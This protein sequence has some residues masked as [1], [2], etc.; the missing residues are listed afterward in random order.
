MHST[1]SNLNVVHGL[2][3]FHPY[4]SNIRIIVDILNTPS[5]E[6][7]Y[8]NHVQVASAKI[9]REFSTTFL[10]LLNL[11]F[12]AKGVSLEIF[13]LRPKDLVSRQPVLTIPTTF[14][15]ETLALALSRSA[16]AQQHA[17]FAKCST[18]IPLSAAL[19]DEFFKIWHTLLPDRNGL[20]LKYI[21]VLIQNSPCPLLRR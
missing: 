16:E 19:P 12:S 13:M 14:L 3:L 1:V 15:L 20:D 4:G 5:Q 6:S 10:E 17:V 8:L 2:T 7:I 9:A 18:P 11:N 21:M